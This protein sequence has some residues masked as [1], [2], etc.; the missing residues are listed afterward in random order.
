MMRRIG[1]IIF[2]A[3]FSGLS[4]YAQGVDGVKFS[5]MV[6]D[7]GEIA[8]GG[9]SVSHT[10]SYTNTS[11][12]PFVITGVE[13]SCGCTTPSYSREPLLG[14]RGSQ[15]VITFEP[16]DRAGYNDKKITLSTNFGVII[17]RITA[18]VLP[19]ERSFDE[20]YPFSFG[21]GARTDLISTS[22]TMM[23][24]GEMGELT[25]GIGNSNTS[26]PISIVV[27]RER[28]PEG[29]RVLEDGGLLSARSSGVIRLGVE[30]LE[31]GSFVHEVYLLVSGKGSDMGISIGGVTV[32]GGD[33]EGDSPRVRLRKRYYSLGRVG[34]GESVFETVEIYNDGAGDL[35]ILGIEY[36]GDLSVDVS[37]RVVRSG[38]VIRLG[39]EYTPSQSGYDSQRVRLLF[40]D[41]AMPLCDIQFMAEVL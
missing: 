26:L 12:V 1:L 31:Y 13:S 17:L 25:I 29:V 16:M 28:L 37:E 5:S 32:F 40:N 21:G 14:G 19:R 34:V 33:A 6:Y 27:D 3:I 10:F 4:L 41:L 15:I 38:G 2:L 7:F 8:E 36:G 35:E 20:R 9:G 23:K 30:G 22:M 39:V 18:E 11:S 24:L